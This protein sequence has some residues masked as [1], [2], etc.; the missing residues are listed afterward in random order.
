[1][2]IWPPQPGTLRRPAYRSLADTVMQAIE[3]GELNYGDR[4][5]THRNLA[6]D[7]GLSV[8]TV[9]RA[10]D[11]LIRRGAIAGEVGR[12]TFVR[13]TRNENRTPYL[14][15]N[16]EGPTIDL[17]L[18]KPVL[19]PVHEELMKGALRD[20]AAD[21]PQTVFSS[22][23][24][25]TALGKYRQSTVKWLRHCGIDLQ[26]QGIM[27]TNGSSPSMSLAL[28]TAA[29]GGDMIAAESL[30]HHTLKP[31]AGYLGYRLRGLPVDR[32][33]MIPEALD[34]L[35]QREGVRV[36]YLMPA[37]LGPQAIVMPAERRAEL[38]EVARRRDLVVLENDAW[39]PIQRERI[40]AIATLAPERTFYFTG[41][42]KCVMPGLRLGFLVMPEALEAAAANRHLV[43]NWMAT[44]M[45]AEIATR[46]IDDGTAEKLARWQSEAF[47]ERNRLA[48]IIL[49]GVPLRASPNGMH[50][51]L[52]MPPGWGEEDFVSHARQQGVAVAP[53]SAFALSSDMSEPAVRVCLGGQSLETLETGLRVIARL[54]R[55][56]FEPALLTS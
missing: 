45:V 28:L 34:R 25:A 47:A 20:L 10:Y 38:V 44:P 22:F 4:L 17:S 21:L 55:S 16:P 18:L 54:V 26:S 33:G 6:Y 14:P 3:A 27:I 43:T 11:E 24:P 1:M 32:H 29:N 42:S 23:R 52:P 30:T 37:G 5:P 53:G 41:L 51:W 48:E 36:V 13:A 31:L 35:A 12:G 7:L 49:A 40:P 39:G 9:G 56:R 8:Q 50:I 46:W 15:R 19:E 2:T